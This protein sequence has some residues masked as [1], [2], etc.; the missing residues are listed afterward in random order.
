MQCLYRHTFLCI[1]QSEKTEIMENSIGRINAEPGNNENVIYNIKY[2]NIW[3]K[4]FINQ[5][6]GFVL[7]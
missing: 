1:E 2:M 3:S 4:E 6:G 5:L 7:V